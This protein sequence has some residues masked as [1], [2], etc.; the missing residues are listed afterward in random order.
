MPFEYATLS[1]TQVRDDLADTLSDLVINA[2]QEGLA[3]L[4]DAIEDEA[5]IEALRTASGPPSDRLVKIMNQLV[6]LEPYALLPEPG[7]QLA[8]AAIQE[9][10][11]AV[12][13][14]SLG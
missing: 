11:R 7:V 5:L 2:G 4:L 9:L 10:R 3:A 8:S 1:L 13:L 6:E 12:G 14:V